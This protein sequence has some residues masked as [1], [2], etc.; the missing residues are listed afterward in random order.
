MSGRSLNVGSGAICAMFL[1][2]TVLM[3]PPAPEQQEMPPPAGQ[4]SGGQP[5]FRAGG[6]LVTARALVRG[7]RG[8]TLTTLTAKDF[9][10]IDN[11]KP[12]A[13]QARQ[14]DSGPVGLALLFDISG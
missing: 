9:D 8:R 2:A 12:I 6:D 11:G 1:G 7:G 14:Q 10:L 13:I 4:V 3:A 5:T